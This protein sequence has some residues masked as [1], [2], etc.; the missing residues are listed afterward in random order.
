MS[1]NF[2]TEIESF[3]FCGIFQENP[4]WP[5]GQKLPYFGTGTVVPGWRLWC[6]KALGVG[7]GRYLCVAL[8]VQ[9]QTC[10][11][12]GVGGRRHRFG[13]HRRDVA[14]YQSI[15][16]NHVQLYA[17]SVRSSSESDLI[18]SQETLG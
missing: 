17:A 14:L 2:E 8:C 12:H 3:L 13:L 5:T 16:W 6:A 7:P 10:T 11:Q 15:C 4:K 18:F 1:H 9:L